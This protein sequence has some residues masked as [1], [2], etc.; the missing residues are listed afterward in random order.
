MKTRGTIV[1]WLDHADYGFIRPDGTAG[2]DV[3]LHRNQVMS[4]EPCRGAVVLFDG[5]IK[6]SRQRMVAS[7]A[8]ILS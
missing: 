6:G 3:F 2:T 8:E 1:S 5:S 7:N 4:G